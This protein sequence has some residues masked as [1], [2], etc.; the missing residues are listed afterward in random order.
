M[1]SELADGGAAASETSEGG[2]SF[3]RSLPTWVFGAAVA[4]AFPVILHQGRLQWFFLDDF[5]FLAVRRLGSWSDLMQPHNGH[6]STLPIIEYRTLYNVVGLNHY[7]PYQVVAVLGHLTVAVLLYLVMRRARV[8]PWIA[9]AAGVLFLFFGAGASDIESAFQ[10]G[11]TGAMAFGLAFLVLVDHPQP[12]RRRDVVGVVCG[13]AALLCSGVGVAVVAATGVAVLLRRGWKVALTLVGPLAAVYVVWYLTYGTQARQPGRPTLTEIRVFVWGA[14]SNPF[15]QLGQVPLLG[16][17]L[18]AVLVAGAIV[19]ARTL[20]RDELRDR[21]SAT[22]GLLAGLV[23]FILVTTVSRAALAHLGADGGARASRYVYVDAAFV[24]PTIAA[25]ATVLARRRPLL[26][27]LACVLLLVGLPGNVDQLWPR[28]VARL[29]LGSPGL[30]AAIAGSPLLAGTPASAQ[31]SQFLFPGMTAGWLRNA[32]ADGKIATDATVTPADA[33]GASLALSLSQVS[34]RT[35]R[36][37]HPVSSA[38][39]ITVDTGDEIELPTGISQVT[40]ALTS[41]GGRPAGLGYIAGDRVLRV[42]RG[43]LDLQIAVPPRSVV[44]VCM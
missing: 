32:V 42:L 34:K 15:G 23:V 41:G 18:A 11:F 7:W 22:I 13:L 12:D 24:L 16:W 36:D 3:V 21:F 31:P 30:V 6:W 2:R 38:G 25:A 5:D 19:A 14:L 37:C 27:A 43:P 29:T 39:T 44:S 35:R 40:Q 1:T 4:V 26:V 9:T 33:R 8:H 28:G 20:P 10:I 17:V